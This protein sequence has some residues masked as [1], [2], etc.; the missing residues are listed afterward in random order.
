MSLGIDDLSFAVIKQSLYGFVA[1]QVR[2]HDFLSILGSHVRIP[3]LVRINDYHGTVA[4]LI[5]AA[6]FVDPNDVLEPAARYLLP[7]RAAHFFAA[8]QRAGFASS[9]NKDVFLID[10]QAPGIPNS[11]TAP[12]YKTLTLRLA[13]TSVVC[14]TKRG[15]FTEF[16][17]NLS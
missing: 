12:D 17:N 1:N 2:F 16:E 8:G 3:D 6:A 4:A 11:P 13:N 14:L 9:A 15:D 7:E 10:F 5:Q